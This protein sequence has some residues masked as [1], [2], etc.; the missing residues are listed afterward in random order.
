MVGGGDAE[1]MHR[2]EE[3]AK[4]PS[5]GTDLPIEHEKWN[6]LHGLGRVSSGKYLKGRFRPTHRA[7]PK[8][9]RLWSGSS[10]ANS[11]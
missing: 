7:S 1:D 6:K 2:R 8:V 4:G 3:A 9:N 5:Y 10:R 11:R